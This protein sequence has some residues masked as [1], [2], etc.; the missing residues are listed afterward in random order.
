MRQY[1]ER[2]GEELDTCG[3]FSGCSQTWSRFRPIWRPSARRQRMLREPAPRLAAWT[4]V[5]LMRCTEAIVDVD[6]EVLLPG[7]GWALLEVVDST[8][9]IDEELLPPAM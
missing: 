8:P 7:A 5:I 2:V 3:A 4:Q 1:V 9:L 6:V